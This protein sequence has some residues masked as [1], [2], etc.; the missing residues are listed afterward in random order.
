[1]LH[2][3]IATEEAQAD[4][5]PPP[6][7]V[8][9]ESDGEVPGADEAPESAVESAALVALPGNADTVDTG[10]V[11][12][13]PALPAGIQVRFSNS[14]FRVADNKL[15]G[16]LSSGLGSSTN[17]RANCSVHKACSCWPNKV[18]DTAESR[19]S[20]ISWLAEDVPVELHRVSAYHLKVR[21]GMTPRKPP[22]A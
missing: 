5:A 21:Y 10:G 6:E 15:L 9:P 4:E 3:E 14:V 17:I 2:H 18:P 11:P 20:L 8:E 12:V 7:E 16:K 22:G 1:M 13:A 19:A